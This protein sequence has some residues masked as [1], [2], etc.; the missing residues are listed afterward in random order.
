V[1]EEHEDLDWF[2]FLDLLGS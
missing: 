2:Q 1:E